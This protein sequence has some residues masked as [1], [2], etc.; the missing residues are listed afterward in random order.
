MDANLAQK[1][2]TALIYGICI[3]GYNSMHSL[4]MVAEC[5]VFLVMSGYYLARQLF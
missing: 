2:S 5:A 4:I 1:N 3:N